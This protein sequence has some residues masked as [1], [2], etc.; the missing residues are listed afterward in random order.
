MERLSATLSAA[1]EHDRLL[2]AEEIA[3]LLS[4]PTRWVREHTRGGLI[5]T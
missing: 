5:R 2:T 4:V 3:E 1:G